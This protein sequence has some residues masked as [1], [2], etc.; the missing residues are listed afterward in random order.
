MLFPELEHVLSLEYG[1]APD[2]RIVAFVERG[3]DYFSLPAPI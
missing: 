3:G 1:F 2:K